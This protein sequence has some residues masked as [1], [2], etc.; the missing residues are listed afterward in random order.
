MRIRGRKIFCQKVLRKWCSQGNFWCVVILMCVMSFILNHCEALACGSVP[1]RAGVSV[2]VG[3]EP[4]F[5]L[6]CT[7]CEEK[8]LISDKSKK[9]C[10]RTLG[11]AKNGALKA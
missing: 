2:S 7:M 10:F 8:Y 1:D 3:S 6:R 4:A 9:V 11:S 5:A